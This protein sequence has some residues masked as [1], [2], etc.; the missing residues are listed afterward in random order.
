MDMRYIAVVDHLV[1]SIPVALKKL[2]DEM[3]EEFGILFLTRYPANYAHVNA[4]GME[5]ITEACSFE[6]DEAME[7]LI[8]P[9]KDRIAAVA[10]RGDKQVQ[11]LR[12]L[13]P[14]LPD[15]VPV[16]SADS[17][18]A[19]TNKRLMRELFQAAYPEITPAHVRVYGPGADAVA[20]VEFAMAYPV[21]VKPASLVS[22]LL[23]QKCADADE[24]S[25]ALETVFEAIERIY[26][27]EDR[28]DSAEVIVE[29]YLLGDFYSVDCYVRKDDMY[30]C[31]PVAYIPAQQLGIDDFFLYKRFVPTKLTKE[32][33]EACFEATGKA[34]KALNLTYS[35][36]HVE[37]ILTANGWKIIEV[38][39]RLGRFRHSM[40]KLGY[41]IDHSY[42]DL[43]VHLDRP[44]IVSDTLKA[45]VTAYSIYPDC[46]GVLDW[47]EG[48][49]RLRDDP[50]VHGL[51][52]IAAPG[53]HVYFAK[54]GGKALAEFIISSDDEAHFKELTA[55]VEGTVKAAISLEK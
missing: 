38:G 12:R 52:V 4:H 24:L 6:D 42:N 15:N 32:E 18:R 47:I 27:R 19:A 17:L 36:A 13:I 39:P 53:E 20:Q 23:I 34:L 45:H 51:K 26:H 48:I 11:F 9:Y 41:G 40:Y 21:I 2:A 46:E 1:S 28:K 49:D 22:S 54:N 7:R 31:P 50:A 3:H 33:T 25:K 44:A 35:A 8:A 29:E 37:L 55:Y 30:F 5:I 43:A 10:C 16:S 14:H